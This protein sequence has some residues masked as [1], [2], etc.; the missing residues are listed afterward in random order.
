[1]R[2]LLRRLILWALSG[3]VPPAHD[4]AGLDKIAADGDVS[5]S[6]SGAKSVAANINV[7]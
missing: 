5:I 4:A 7:S 3:A 1:M 2:A 6:G